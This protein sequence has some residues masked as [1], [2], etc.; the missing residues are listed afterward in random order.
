MGLKSQFPARGT[1][2]CGKLNGG[3]WVKEKGRFVQCKLI[4]F[5]SLSTCHQKRSK[6][7]S[8]VEEV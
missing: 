3:S 8:L 4:Q 7:I 2:K 1:E 5:Q 6:I